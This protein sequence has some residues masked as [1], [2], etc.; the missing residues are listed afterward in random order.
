MLGITA[1][2]CKDSSTSPSQAL[3]SEL[4]GTWA[5]IDKATGTQMAMIFSGNQISTSMAGSE[6]YSGTFSINTN[7]SPK[8]INFTITSS[9]I[10]AYVGQTSLGV[11]ELSG[12][13]LTIAANEPGDPVRPASITAGRVFELAKE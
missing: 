11:Y 7:I 10:S 8:Q 4:E 2:G 12:N 3:T 6:L 13:S 9:S 1:A 5:G